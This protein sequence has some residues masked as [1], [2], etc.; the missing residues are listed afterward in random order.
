M[1]KCTND[2]RRYYYMS[3]NLI[4]INVMASAIIFYGR[5]EDQYGGFVVKLFY[6]KLNTRW[7]YKAVIL[8]KF[9]RLFRYTL[10]SYL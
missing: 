8:S 4:D 6:A 3:F 10:K 9:I 1:K 2:S 7:Y 5:R